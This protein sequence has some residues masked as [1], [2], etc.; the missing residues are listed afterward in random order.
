MHLIACTH[1]FSPTRKLFSEPKGWWM[2]ARNSVVSLVAPARRSSCMPTV[3]KMPIVETRLAND[4]KPMDRHELMTLSEYSNETDRT[5]Q[6]PN[7]DLTVVSFC[8]LTHLH[9]H[10][11]CSIA[12]C[13]FH[14]FQLPQTNTTTTD[15]ES[16]PR[17][18][19]DLPPDF[20]VPKNGKTPIKEPKKELSDD[21]ENEGLCSLLS[22]QA[23]VG[24]TKFDFPSKI[25]FKAR[26]LSIS[27]L[28]LV[29]WK[30]KFDYLGE[31]MLL[32]KIG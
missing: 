16:N 29:D 3:G 19:K 8:I 6:P 24:C 13:E 9:E 18:I 25:G 32:K 30:Q 12:F 23:R 10:F 4:L 14:K 31:K 15:T 28:S 21:E 7:E 1:N 20:L 11:R 26:L 27:L 22:K 2:S 5:P 17:P